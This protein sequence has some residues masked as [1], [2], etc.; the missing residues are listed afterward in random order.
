MATKKKAA[1]SVSYYLTRSG[2]L[3]DEKKPWLSLLQSLAESFLTRK[4]DFTRVIIPGQ[5]LQAD[6]FD[7]TAQ[8]AAYLCASVRLSMMW[9]D[10]SRTFTIEPARRLRGLPGVEEYFRFVT[11]EMYE[12]MDNPKAGLQMALMEY[13]LDTGVFGTGA[14]AALDGP[15][16]D[17]ALPVIFDSW[18][19]KA[20]TIAETAQGL[21]DTIYFK[22]Q[23]TVRQVM[24]EYDDEG[25]AVSPKVKEKFA[26][27]K[28]GEKVNIL[29]I[30]EPKMPEAEKK[31][32]AAMSC[33]TVH[34]DM[35]NEFM[36]REGGYEEMPVF[37]G[38]LFKTTD[39]PYGRSFGMIAQPDAQ[40][41]NALTEAVLV[42]ADKLLDPP[43]YILDDGR[44]GGGVID[45]SAGGLNVFNSAGRINNEKPI[46]SINTV[47]EMTNALEQQKELKGKVMQAFL[48]DRLL[49]LNNT[50]QMTA[51]ET[52][53]RDRKAGQAAGGIFS[54]DEK[55]VFTPLIHRVF[56][57]MFRKGYLGIVKNGP[58]AK[59]LAA[60]DKVVGGQK[61]IV[62]KAVID[63]HAAGLDVF[64][65]KYISPAKRF[66]QAEKL[67]GIFTTVDA[68]VALAPV[69]IGVTDNIDGDQLAHDIYE[70]GGAPKTSLR[71]GDK[72]LQFR[73]AN[74]KKAADQEQLA[75]GE[76]QANV[77]LKSAQA[78]QAMGTTAAGPTGK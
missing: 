21:V 56:N 24:L 26:A 36:M 8:F 3:D 14:V 35:D 13:F 44:L 52:S 62:P 40:S 67:Q 7:N 43:L 32:L 72:L 61:M 23:L 28:Y 10:S 66:Q 69:I 58:G 57:Q 77:A 9:P 2:E 49:D 15:D 51:Y 64:N 22:R 74:A 37:V 41:L 12:A 55:E 42:A 16:D 70:Y 59:Q 33:R 19:V 50:T 25:D 60:W 48:L 78:R 47:G 4:M 17:A 53:V 38:R 20:M 1:S 39:E 31:G 6:V 45:T 65:V 34:I 63:A 27:K 29:V 68:L 71:T 54:R 30:I 75:A 76:Q 73:A 11:E 18:S 5:F 46:G